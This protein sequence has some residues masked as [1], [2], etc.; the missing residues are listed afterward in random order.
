MAQIIDNRGRLRAFSGCRRV[1]TDPDVR[2]LLLY[3]RL[4]PD[5]IG[6]LE[7]RNFYL[8]RALVQRGHE[9]TLAGFGTGLREAPPGVR[10]QS[11]GKLGQL[12]SAEGR[13]STWRA[14][15]FAW[16]LCRLDVSE[17]DVVETAS[18]PYI[19]L[20]P[21]AARCAL[22]RKPLLV[23][24][25]EFWGPYWKKYLGGWR[26]PI[27]RA[28]EWIVAQ[29]GTAV[30][31]S[32]ALTAGRLAARRLRRGGVPIVP[33]GIHLDGI[34]DAVS[35]MTKSGGHLIYAGRLIA[36]KRVDV[37]I[38][39]LAQL[40]DIRLVVFGDGPQLTNLRALAERLGVDSRI[41]FRGHVADGKEVW[42]SVAQSS[43]AVQPSSREGFGIFPLEAM[44][45]GVPVVYLEAADSAVGEIVRDRI[46]GICVAADA[47]SLAAAVRDLL[48]DENLRRTLGECGSLRARQFD[49]QIVAS[50]IEPLL[51]A[52]MNRGA[53]RQP[54]VSKL[55]TPPAGEP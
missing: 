8:A 3:E 45:V 26:A 16:E 28:V 49:S 9:V 42:R 25:Y 20:V 11:F 13:R 44:A 30:I 12:Y 10:F 46:E 37:L 41:D 17:Y 34:L 51:A 47:D 39:A 32:S 55:I 4:Y 52:M 31:A 24:W 48:R 38:K 5:S 40:P 43:I 33:C 53:Q 7:R 14:L 35:G 23:T 36:E 29:F 27:Y 2:V 1:G 50:E 54:V 15:R 18:V 22:A 19:H 6:G 21:L